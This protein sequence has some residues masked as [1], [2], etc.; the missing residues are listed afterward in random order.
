[1]VIHSRPNSEVSGSNPGPYKGKL[2]VAYRWSA[3]YSTEPS[4]TICTSAG[5]MFANFGIIARWLIAN[6]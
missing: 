3:I 2:L 4:P 5:T 6:Q 1:M